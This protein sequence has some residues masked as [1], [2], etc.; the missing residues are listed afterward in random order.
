MIRVNDEV[1]GVIGTKSVRGNVKSIDAEAVIV[2]YENGTV[3]KYSLAEAAEELF[4]SEKALVK[5]FGSKIRELAAPKRV[6]INEALDFYNLPV[7]TGDYLVAIAGNPLYCRV[8][9]TIEKMYK[10]FSEYHPETVYVDLRKKADQTF[11]KVE[12]SN[13]CLQTR[14]A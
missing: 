3:I 5:K 8:E 2:S 14:F 12:V 10:E 6:E 13:L 1:Y 11:T 4:T 7:K 9:G